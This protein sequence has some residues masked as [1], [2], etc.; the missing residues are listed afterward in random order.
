[1]RATFVVWTHY[2]RRPELLARQLGAT[3]HYVAWGRRGA[4]LQAPARY[5]VQAAQTWRNL[6]RERPDVVFA[7][8]PPIFCGL[9][10]AAYARRCG[11]R[12]VLDSHS[13]AFLSPKWRWS[14]PLHRALARGAATTI[15]QNAPLAEIVRGWGAP[16]SLLGF[17]PGDYPDGERVPLAAAFNVAVISTY[18]EDE[19]LGVVLDAAARLPDVAFYVTGD[20][21]RADPWLR[22][23]KPANCHLTGYLTYERYIGLLRAADAVVDLTTSDN[24]LLMGAYEAVALGRP[25]IVSDWPVLRDYFSCG[26]I[27]IPNTAEGLCNAVGRARREQAALARDIAALR[28]RLHDEWRLGFAEL[29]G[30][31]AAG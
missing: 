9:V 4:A 2:D 25:L 17:T 19:P 13:G 7:Q 18:A 1:M 20:A 6:R 3:L 15:V 28:E 11:A 12:Y 29:Q 30:R 8:N 22:E 14:A 16:V 21:R 5:L 10:A 31:L 27:H 26:A 24:T 23:R